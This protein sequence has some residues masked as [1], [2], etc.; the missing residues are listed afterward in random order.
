[1]NKVLYTKWGTA[2][3][4]GDGY[5]KITSGKEG[6][7]GK[8][9][10]RLIWE[11]YYGEIPEGMLVHHRNGIKTDNSIQNLELISHSEHTHMHNKDRIFSDESRRKMS[12]SHKGKVNSQATRKK[13]SENNAR[14]WKGKK[15]DSETCEKISKANKG[16]KHSR[17]TVLKRAK[18]NTKHYPRIVKKGFSDNGKQIYCILLYGKCLKKSVDYKKLEKELERLMGELD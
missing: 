18:S 7:H 5:Y 9:L 10:H 4:S 11:S 1:M 2:R 15:R 12:E 8:R 3:V 16:K 14:Y 17:E 13:M 6:Y